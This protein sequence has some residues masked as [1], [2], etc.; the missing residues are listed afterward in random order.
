MRFR[1]REGLERDKGRERERER[2]RRKKKVRGQK[3]DMRNE[4][5]RGRYELMY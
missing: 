5:E 2:E 1:E 3:G 4:G